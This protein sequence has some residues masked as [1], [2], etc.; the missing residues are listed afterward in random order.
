[1]EHYVYVNEV[2]LKESSPS[3][4]NAMLKYEVNSRRDAPFFRLTK[5]LFPLFI[6]LLPVLFSLHRH[7]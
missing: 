5:L 2:S 3:A 1:M 6:L 7:F 4:G